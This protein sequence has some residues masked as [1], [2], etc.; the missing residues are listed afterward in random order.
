MVA[1]KNVQYEPRD[2]PDTMISSQSSSLVM[3]EGELAEPDG[4]SLGLF[5]NPI[6]PDRAWPVVYGGGGSNSSGGGNFMISGLALILENTPSNGCNWIVESDLSS[7]FVLGWL[8]L[9]GW[10]WDDGCSESKVDGINC[11]DQGN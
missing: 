5:D 10:G 11:G 6:D 2:L 1:K 9:F 8:G 7:E 3:A 4:K